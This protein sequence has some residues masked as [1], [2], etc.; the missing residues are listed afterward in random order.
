[1]N[2]KLN[3]RKAESE[4]ERSAQS[5]QPAVFASWPLGGC[6]PL[7]NQRLTNPGEKFGDWPGVTSHGLANKATAAIHSSLP[8][9][10]WLV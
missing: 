9:V 1:M 7:K 3:A 5:L 6:D 10:T 2:S 4:R 8:V